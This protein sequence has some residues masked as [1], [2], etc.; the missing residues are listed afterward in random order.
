M[1]KG[2]LY[3]LPHEDTRTIQ[4]PLYKDQKRRVEHCRPTLK[5]TA[6]S[7][8]LVPISRMKVGCIYLN[9]R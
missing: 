4:I 8:L 9:E 7:C 6:R 3:A 2:P 5:K 1:P